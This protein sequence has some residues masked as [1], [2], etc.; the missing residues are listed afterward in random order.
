MS[1]FELSD[2][3]VAKM[4]CCEKGEI[5]LSFLDFYLSKAITFILLY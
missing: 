3:S 2:I 1:T 4:L 5:L